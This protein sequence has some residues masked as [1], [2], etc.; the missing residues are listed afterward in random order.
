MIFQFSSLFIL[1][2]LLLNFIIFDLHLDYWPVEDRTD[3]SVTVSSTY[4]YN[5]PYD[6]YA[7]DGE[8][9]HNGDVSL[10]KYLHVC[11]EPE[12]PKWLGFWQEI[13]KTKL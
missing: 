5:S 4:P 6:Y 7:I 3:W 11:K 12:G 9:T 1:I 10:K 8:Y 13:W 2:N